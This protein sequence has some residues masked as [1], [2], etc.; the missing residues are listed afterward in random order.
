MTTPTLNRE[1]L[2]R[3]AE[4]RVAEARLLLDNGHYPGAYYLAGYAVECALK[5]C[6]A[7]Q[8]REFDFPDRK[9]TDKSYSHSLVRLLGTAQLD[10]A[11][12]Q[13]QKIAP[14]LGTNW[15]IVAQWSV[16]SRYQTDV[17]QEC[18]QRL[19]SAITNINNG[20]LHWIKMHW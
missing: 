15:E 4:L 7:K 8:V 2:Q 16:E 14:E 10:K 18:C 1:S 6:I 20:I 9:L 17:S 11:L 3:L 13:A 5:A 12:A 19:Y